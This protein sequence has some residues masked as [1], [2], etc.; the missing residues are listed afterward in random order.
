MEAFGLWS[1]R[2]EQGAPKLIVAETIVTLNSLILAAKVPVPT[3]KSNPI[4]ISP[5]LIPRTSDIRKSDVWFESASSLTHLGISWLVRLKQSAHLKNP[6]RVALPARQAKFLHRLDPYILANLFS[7]KTSGFRFEYEDSVPRNDL[8]EKN[9]D[10][11][12]AE[13]RRAR[14][15]DELSIKYS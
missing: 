10:M 8:R 4:L 2:E 11:A 14:T 13:R 15:P 6:L 1:S 12:A 3:L 9:L 7:Q 5:G